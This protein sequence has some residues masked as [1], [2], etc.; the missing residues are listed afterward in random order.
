MVPEFEGA[1]F[2]LEVDEISD[3]VRSPFG[4][5]VIKLTEKVEETTQP[6]SEVRTEIERTLRQ[7]QASARAT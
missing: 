6:L 2:A 1:A 7:E 5:H 3:P 4:F